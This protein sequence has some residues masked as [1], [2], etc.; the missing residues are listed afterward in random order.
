[1]FIDNT[2]SLII[3]F[4]QKLM[5]KPVS[6]PRRGPPKAMRTKLTATPKKEEDPPFAK[7]IK[8]AKNTIAV[9]SFI[10]DSPSMRVLNLTLAPSSLSS[11]TT[12]TGSVADRTHPKVSASYHPSYSSG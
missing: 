3:L 10:K 6:S 12:A 11:A 4:I 9:P 2:A 8:S 5:T 1:M 7:S